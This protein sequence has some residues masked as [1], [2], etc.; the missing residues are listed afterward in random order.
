MRDLTG[1]GR[2]R[3]ALVAGGWAVG[4]ACSGYSATD[5]SDWCQRTPSHAAQS[6]CVSPE[7]GQVN[8]PQGLLTAPSLKARA[9]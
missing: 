2:T 7:L 6:G 4:A 1:S 5:Y 3:A 9:V 8:P